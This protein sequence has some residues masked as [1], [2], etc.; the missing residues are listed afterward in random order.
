MSL[1]L[2]AGAALLGS[3][4]T[5]SAD[6]PPGIAVRAVG[7]FRSATVSWNSLSGTV[8]QIQ[9]FQVRY[10]INDISESVWTDIPGSGHNTTRHTLTGLADNTVYVILIRGVNADGVGPGDF[11]V[12]TTQ[13]LPVRIAPW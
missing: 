13:A 3:P 5:A 1:L 4:G 6:P 2:V 8:P 11:T 12:V 10:Y 9:K 7:G